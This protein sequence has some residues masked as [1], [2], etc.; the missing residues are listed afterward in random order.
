MAKQ[1]FPMH[2]YRH[3]AGDWQLHA[4]EGIGRGYLTHVGVVQVECEVP[5]N[6]DLRAAKLRELQAEK[7]RVRAELTK[8]ITD[9]TRQINEL[10]ALEMTEAA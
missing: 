6:F 9:L 2:L 3:E 1:T 7:Q 4:Y 5:E 8:R 10:S